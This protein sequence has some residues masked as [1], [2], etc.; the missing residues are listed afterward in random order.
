MQQPFSFNP[1]NPGSFKYQILNWLKKF[2]TFSLLDSNAFYSGKDHTSHP[3]YHSYDFL[4]AAGVKEEIILDH[5]NSIEQLKKFFTLNEDW[6]FGYLGYD[7]KNEIENL[8][9]RNPDHLNFSEL[10]FFIPNILITGKED[11]FKIYTQTTIQTGKIL[12][13]IEKQESLKPETSETRDNITLKSRVSRKDY[14]QN[15]EKIKKNIL[16]GDVYE[17][18][19]CQEFFNSGE[20][21]DPFQL[22]SN[23]TEINPA[24]FSCFLRFND[25]YIISFTMERFL[26]KAG[27]KLISQPIKG[28]IKRGKSAEK[29]KALMKELQ[30]D[31][32]E[33]AENVMIVDL[34]RNDL[35]RSAKTGSVNVE[36]LFGIYSFPAVHQ[37]ISTV[38]AQIRDEVHFLDTIKNAFPMGSMTGAPKVKAMELI[39]KYESTKRGVF[40]GAVGYITPWQDFDFNVIIRTFLYDQVK[41]Y[42]SLPVGSAITFDS[43]P[44]KEYEE[45]KVKIE[46]LR[47]G[48]A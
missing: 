40:S 15:V 43:S 25:Q 29:D 12:E 10:H 19:Y 16:E 14:Y 32:K 35:A 45:C 24:P 41:K 1:E 9:S 22:Y 7:L 27:N 2:K 6:L 28:T 38:T 11:S 46:K 31:P 39:E 21:I 42:L 3:F 4:A 30:K 33:R 36:E 37:M 8:D 17:I 34:V 13:E 23:L 47:K 5:G 48:L 18:N 20:K 44:A 26:K